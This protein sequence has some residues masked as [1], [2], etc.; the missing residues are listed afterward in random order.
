MR[1]KIFVGGLIVGFCLAVTYILSD[2]PTTLWDCFA[3]IV[4]GAVIYF[5]GVSINVARKKGLGVIVTKDS[6]S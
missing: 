6:I 1:V 4:I 2:R 3:L 5:I